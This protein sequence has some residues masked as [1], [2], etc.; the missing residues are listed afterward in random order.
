MACVRNLIKFSTGTVNS[1]IL[2]DRTQHTRLSSCCFHPLSFLD[3]HSQ[4]SHSPHFPINAPILLLPVNLLPTLNPV[5][6]VATCLRRSTTRPHDDR[7]SQG[8]LAPRKTECRRS[9]VCVILESRGNQLTNDIRC[10][11]RRWCCREGMDKPH[12]WSKDAL[13]I[14]FPPFRHAFSSPTRPMLFQ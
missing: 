3:I 12:Q 7:L 2:L 10:C 4:G 5:L 11:C 6:G 9:N 8:I 13:L 14:Q 1:L